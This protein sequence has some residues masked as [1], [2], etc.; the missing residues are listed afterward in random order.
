MPPGSVPIDTERLAAAERHETAADLQVMQLIAEHAAVSK[1]VR[2]T[3]VRVETTTRTR[4]QVVEAD[5]NHDQ[6]VVERVAIGRVVD[7]VPDVRQE[8]D[9]TILP[10]IEEEVVVM[11]RL[12]LKEEVHVRRVRTTERHVETVTLRAQE[13]AVTRTNLED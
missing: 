2:K 13:A 5:L 11:R 10:V 8:G 12:V 6:V 3:K 7:A 9:V 4:D 1:R